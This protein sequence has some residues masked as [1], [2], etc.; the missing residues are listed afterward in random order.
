MFISGYPVNHDIIVE[1]SLFGLK[2][3]NFALSA[4]YRDP[5]ESISICCVLSDCN[6]IVEQSYF[7]FIFLKNH[8]R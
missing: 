7:S 2:V 8:L 5:H 4:F 6:R 1:E 3:S